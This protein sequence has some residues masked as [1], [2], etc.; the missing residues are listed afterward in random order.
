VDNPYPDPAIGYPTQDSTSDYTKI[1]YASNS[2]FRTFIWADIG[3][4]TGEVVIDFQVQTMIGNAY[5]DLIQ[6][7]DPWIFHGETSDWSETQTLNITE[8]Q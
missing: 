3:S 7:G 2:N 4:Q 5:V 6:F 1:T 8:S